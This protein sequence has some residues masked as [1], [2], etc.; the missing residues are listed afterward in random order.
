MRNPLFADM[1]NAAKQNKTDTAP[2]EEN[3]APAVVTAAQTSEGKKAVGRPARQ[4]EAALRNTWVRARV[5][6]NELMEIKTYC[7]NHKTSVDELVRTAVLD[8]VRK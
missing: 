2:I 1:M 8:I 4:G 7:V 5:S 3:V 6:E